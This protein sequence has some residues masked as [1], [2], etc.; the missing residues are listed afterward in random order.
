MLA[1]CDPEIYGRN[2][3]RWFIELVL[4]KENI[5]VRQSKLSMSEYSLKT[6]FLV[7]EYCL[8]FIFTSQHMLSYS[9]Y[10]NR[11]Y[12]EIVGRVKSF[13]DSVA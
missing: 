7:L 8:N 1:Q 12:D 13:S 3:N 11:D 2:T 10:Y 9:L 5:T 4:T 6:Q